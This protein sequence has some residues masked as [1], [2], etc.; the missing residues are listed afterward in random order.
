MA[1][2]YTVLGNRDVAELIQNYDLT[3][4]QARRYQMRKDGMMLKEIAEAEGVGIVPV[5]DSLKLAER[6]IKG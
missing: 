1:K 5:H 6:K 2:D 3:Y 4:S